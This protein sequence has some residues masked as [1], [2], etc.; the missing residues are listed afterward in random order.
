MQR[1]RSTTRNRT[2]NPNVHNSTSTH[3]G[4]RETIQASIHEFRT[5]AI[6]KRLLQTVF[7]MRWGCHCNWPA[8][9]DMASP[10]ATHTKAPQGWITPSDS[11]H[12]HSMLAEGL[13]DLIPNVLRFQMKPVRRMYMR[14]VVEVNVV[15][16]HDPTR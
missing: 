11:N 7:T 16:V 12:T 10:G 9:V 14:R 6:G 4:D 15:N 3:E 2:Y 8:T 1:Q 13:V 5:F